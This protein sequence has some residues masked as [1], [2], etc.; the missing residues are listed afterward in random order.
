MRQH[1][2]RQ[3]AATSEFAITFLQLPPLPSPFGCRQ[4]ANC[5]FVLKLLLSYSLFF[6]VLAFTFVL[7]ILLTNFYFRALY[8]LTCVVSTFLANAL[9]LLLFF[10]VPPC[11]SLHFLVGVVRTFAISFRVYFRDSATRV[12]YCFLFFYVKT[13]ARQTRR[14]ATKMQPYIS[15]ARVT[16]SIVF[17]YCEVT[18][19]PRG[20]IRVSESVTLEP[21]LPKTASSCRNS[22]ANT[23]YLL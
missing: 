9:A 18:H 3:A 4:P 13:N 22:P 21:N 8:L 2:F 20:W 19:N 1:L 7:L 6:L 11:F 23:L 14:K 10:R 17:P 16:I 5:F 15:V 12:V